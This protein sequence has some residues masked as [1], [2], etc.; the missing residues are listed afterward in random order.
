MIRLTA[1]RA[2][3]PA[4]LFHI[5]PVFSALAMFGPFYTLVFLIFALCCTKHIKIKK[6]LTGQGKKIKANF[7]VK[8]TESNYML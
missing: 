4:F 1:S 3:S 5:L 6:I 2:T 8:N 7:E